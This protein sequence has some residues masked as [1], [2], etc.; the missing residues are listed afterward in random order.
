MPQGTPLGAGSGSYNRFVLMSGQTNSYAEVT[1]SNNA[2]VANT[3]Y[4]ADMYRDGSNVKCKVLQTYA[5]IHDKEVY[6]MQQDGV[7][8]HTTSSP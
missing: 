4:W 1:S 8:N 5:K 7:Q 6:R 2:L 3:Q